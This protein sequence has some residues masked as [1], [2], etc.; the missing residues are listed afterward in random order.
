MQY[1]LWAVKIIVFLLLFGFA[2]HN[3][4]PV[5]LQFFL[6]YSWRTPLIVLLLL[7]FVIGALLGLLASFIFV[8]RVR[9][10]LLQLKKE[11]RHKS[12]VNTE[13]NPPIDGVVDGSLD[14][15]I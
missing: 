10:E 5:D 7:F 4:Q 1:L 2:M 12:V 6:G 14:P 3:T 8:M 15:S 11:L 13:L 9:K